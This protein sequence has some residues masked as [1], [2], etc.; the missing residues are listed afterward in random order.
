MTTPAPKAHYSALFLDVPIGDLPSR[1][2]ARMPV[3]RDRIVD[4]AGVWIDGQLAI[5]R[6][7]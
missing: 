1:K 3:A 7:L 6:W 2:L 4:T 5:G